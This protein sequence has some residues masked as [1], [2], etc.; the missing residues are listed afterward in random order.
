[1]ATRKKVDIITPLVVLGTGILSQELVSGYAAS[2]ATDLKGKAE[3][4]LG[5]VTSNI[6]SVAIILAVAAALIYVAKK[7]LKL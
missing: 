6:K 7:F 2:S 3:D 5:S 1:M 4:A